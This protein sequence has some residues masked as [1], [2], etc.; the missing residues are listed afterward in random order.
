MLGEESSLTQ[1]RMLWGA[2]YVLQGNWAC[3]VINAA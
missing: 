1:K 3:R 2:V